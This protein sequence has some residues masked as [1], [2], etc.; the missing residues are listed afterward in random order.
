MQHHPCRFH[1]LPKQVSVGHLYFHHLS[2]QNQSLDM[3]ESVTVVVVNISYFLS[4]LWLTV[5]YHIMISAFM[6]ILWQNLSSVILDRALKSLTCCEHILLFIVSLID[7]VEKRHYL[8]PYSY[9]AKM[10]R[11]IC[12]KVWQL[13]LLWTYV[14]FRHYPDW[15]RRETSPHWPCS[16]LFTCHP[17]S[18]ILPQVAE[19]N[20]AGRGYFNIYSLLYI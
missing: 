4:L 13:L 19:N 20:L 18:K 5:P 6:I 3:L 9:F 1:I 14:T 12:W 15:P 10:S 8:D 7:H 11:R 2:E 17:V 16:R